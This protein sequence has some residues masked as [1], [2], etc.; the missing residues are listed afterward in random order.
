[1]LAQLMP[2]KRYETWVKGKRVH[3]GTLYKLPLGLALTD[4]QLKRA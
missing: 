4:A 3:T 1:M 2:R